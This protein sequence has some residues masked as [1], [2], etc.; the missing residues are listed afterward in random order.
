MRSR[1][2]LEWLL[3]ISLFLSAALEMHG[4]ADALAQQGTVNLALRRQDWGEG[5][6]SG[7][8]KACDLLP[9]FHGCGSQFAMMFRWNVVSWNLEEV[10]DR[11]VD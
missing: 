9:S 1:V 2:K 4:A 7:G 11:V 5:F 8:A 10:G 6:G 3:A